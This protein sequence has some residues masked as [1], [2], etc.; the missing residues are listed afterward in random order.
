MTQITQSERLYIREFSI[1]DAENMYSLNL[2]PE[3]IKYTGDSHFNSITDAENF[4]KNYS[5][6]KKYGFGRW[7]LINRENNNFIGWCGIKFTPDKNEVDL[8]FRILK[9]NWNRGYA[10]EASIAVLKIAFN[11][12]NLDTI[13][14]RTNSKN[15]ASIRT[16]EKLGFTYKNEID[17]DGEK[18]C[19][20]E[21]HKTEFCI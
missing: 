7:V 8:G 3:V 21:I 12:F 18:G 16:L 10:T 17:F 9:S 20:Y 1:S 14:G 5:H 19:Q 2:D 11:K 4:I 15:I 6:Y 13:V